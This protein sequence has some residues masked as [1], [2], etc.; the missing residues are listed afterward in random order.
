MRFSRLV[1][2][3][4][5][6]GQRLGSRFV[7]ALAATTL[8][9]TLCSAACGEGEPL[10]VEG[11]AP[12]DHAILKHVRGG[13]FFVA[14]DLKQQYD[15]LLA[16]VRNLQAAVAAD[17]ISGADALAELHELEPKLEALRK[18]IDAKKVLV[19]PVKV[20]TQT[21]KSEFDLG[22]ERLLVITAD[23]V[24]VVGWDKPHVKC[25]LEKSVFG[26]SDT[27]D[28]EEF[29]AIRLVHRHALAPDL[30]GKTN[31]DYAADED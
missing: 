3:L 9:A 29:K 1:L 31:A 24:R 2:N 21:E 10:K 18:E 11:E 6:C 16:R 22:P 20:R 25:F 30:V 28:N 23:R 12:A 5:S 15:S 13:A 26:G 17:Q 4:R 8:A 14:K 19:S 27:T 7:R